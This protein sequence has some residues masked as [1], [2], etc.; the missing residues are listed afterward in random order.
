VSDNA[1]QNPR[2]T[3]TVNLYELRRELETIAAVEFCTVGDVIRRACSYEVRRVRQAQ[4]RF[5]RAPR[6]GRGRSAGG[7]S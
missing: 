5:E 7:A 2:S 3:F 6:S 1:P 4:R